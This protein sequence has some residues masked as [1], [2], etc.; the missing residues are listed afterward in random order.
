MAASKGV[1]RPFEHGTA[2]GRGA[3]AAHVLWEHEVVGSNPTAP[4]TFPAGVTFLT[5]ITLLACVKACV[6]LAARVMVSSAVRGMRL[7]HAPWR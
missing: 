3:T 6:T 1:S 5:G 7:T 4:T 2:S